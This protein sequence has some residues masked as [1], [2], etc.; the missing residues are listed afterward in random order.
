MSIIFDF[1]TAAAV[2][3]FRVTISF[4]RRS[5]QSSLRVNDGDS[6]NIKTKG[7]GSKELASEKKLSALKQHK[8]G[9]IL[10]QRDKRVI[11]ADLS[12]TSILRVINKTKSSESTSATVSSESEPA[13]DGTT[14][15]STE[16]EGQEY[17]DTDESSDESGRLK[18]CILY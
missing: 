5:P 3:A 7:A 9:K 11:R 17:S 14:S 8:L 15:P 4:S 18:F 13:N 12:K 1:L 10:A 2:A 16:T 6:L